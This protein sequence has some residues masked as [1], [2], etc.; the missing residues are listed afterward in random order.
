MGI[1]ILMVVG[2]LLVLF[3]ISFF[4]GNVPV[5]LGGIIGIF[6]FFGVGNIVATIFE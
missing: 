4:V 1:F 3:G 2:N 6:V 5:W